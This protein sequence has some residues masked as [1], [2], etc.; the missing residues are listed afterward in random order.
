MTAPK[1][2]SNGWDLA[3]LVGQLIDH[4]WIIVAVTAF[5]ML[6]ATLYTLF[7]TPIYSADAMVQVEQ[8][9]TASVLNE[10]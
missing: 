9:N 2:D 10:L 6:M 4:R 3:H 8:K 1:E 5:F 7:A